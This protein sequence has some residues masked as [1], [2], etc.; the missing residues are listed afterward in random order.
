[1]F[2]IVYANVNAPICDTDTLLYVGIGVGHIV[3][4]VVGDPFTYGWIFW[5]D[6]A[7]YTHFV[8]L[9]INKY[10]QIFS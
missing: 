10:A 5:L 9:N 4:D 7:L 1:M 6:F 3:V 8:L 2:S